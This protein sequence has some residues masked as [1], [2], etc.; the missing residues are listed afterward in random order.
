MTAKRAYHHGDLRNALLAAGLDL[1]EARGEAELSL[2]GIAERAG[3][4]HAA[5][6]HHFGNLKGLLTALVTLA[7]SWFEAALAAE[8]AAAG[9]GAADQLRAAGRGYL[10]FARQ[11][12]ALFRLMF[13]AADLDW[14]DPGL[15]SAATAARRHLSEIS[16]PAANAAGFDAAAIE[17][18]VWSAVHGFAVLSI[19][20]H[21]SA[22]GC[23]QPGE[24]PDIAGLIYGGRAIGGA[25]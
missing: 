12:P 8:R 14:S 2:R 4:S 5:P 23:A 17:T 21:L 15:Q 25:G 20:G 10:T 18:L 1:L 11:R 22:P 13:S 24:L 16:A 6:A 7:Y 9:A 3:V 19:D